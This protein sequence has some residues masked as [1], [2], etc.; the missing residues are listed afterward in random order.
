MKKKKAKKDPNAPKRPLSAYFLYVSEPAWRHNTHECR[1]SHGIPR[2]SH[3]THTRLVLPQTAER[4]DALK[5]EQPDIAFGEMGK[6]MGSEWRAM[7]EAKKAPYEKKAEAA[8][9]SEFCAETHR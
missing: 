2:H 7:S 4:R 6:V 3:G 1:H 5:K 9:A 8:K